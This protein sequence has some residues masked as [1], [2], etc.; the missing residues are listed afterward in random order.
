MSDAW[1]QQT[2]QR[3]ESLFFSPWPLTH[4]VPN[5]AS[6]FAHLRQQYQQEPATSP[7]ES[8]S[9]FFVMVAT[10]GLVRM[11]ETQDLESRRQYGLFVNHLQDAETALLKAIQIHQRSL[12]R[13]VPPSRVVATLPTA[14]TTATNAAAVTAIA[15]A[16]ASLGSNLPL[17]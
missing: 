8:L 17:R 4:P 2:L 10:W 1:G 5:V 9:R 13:P 7:A 15:P 11:V 3:V 6:M 14:T 16:E 12:Q